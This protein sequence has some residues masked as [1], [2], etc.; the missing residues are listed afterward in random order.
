MGIEIEKKTYVTVSAKDFVDGLNDSDLC[1]LISEVSHKFDQD[2]KK[3]QWMAS[4]FASHL[5]EDSCRF[6][7]EIVTQHFARKSEF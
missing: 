5:S 3:R 6:M 7:A 1:E 4:T 2:Y